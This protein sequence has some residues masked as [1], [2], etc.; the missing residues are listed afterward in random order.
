MLNLPHLDVSEVGG[1]DA[2]VVTGDWIARIGPVMRSLSPGASGWWATVMATATAFYQRWL[3]ADPL[4]RLSIK[5]EAV[6]HVHDFGSLSRV[7]ERGSV[8]ILQAMPTELQSEAVSTRALNC[9]ALLFLTMSR[10]QPGGSAEKASILAFLTQPQTEGPAG[11]VANHTALR[12]WERLFRRCTELGLQI[13]D[14]SLLVRA[15]DALGK[16]IGNKSPTAAWRL[17]SFRHQH[18]L[19]VQP[20]E[21]AVLKYCQLLTAELETL[22]L[23]QDAQKQQRVSV[24]QAEAPKVPRKAPTKAAPK[25][26][27][28]RPQPQ[29]P[30]PKLSSKSH[31]GP[32]DERGICKFFASPGGCRYGRTCLHPHEQL[33]PTDGRCFNCGAVGHSVQECD[34][35]TKPFPKTPVKPVAAESPAKSTTSSPLPKGG[36]P[37]RKPKGRKL[38]TALDASAATGESATFAAAAF[39]SEGDIEKMLKRAAC[40][41]GEPHIVATLNGITVGKTR[42]LL[43]GGATHSLRHAA[44][45]E[46]RLARPVQVHLASGSTFDLR[47]NAVGTLLSEDPEVQPIVP[48]G[49]LAEELGCVI[50]WKG[51]ECKVVHPELGKLGVTVSRGCPEVQHDVCLS[52]ILELEE[53]RSDSMLGKV[54]K[55]QVT[56]PLPSAIHVQK[57]EKTLQYLQEKVAEWFPEVPQ[58]TRARLLPRRAYP[59]AASG[60]NRHC[61]RKLERG[62]ALIHLFAWKQKNQHPSAIPAV[63]LDLLSGH[64]LRDDALFAYLLQ[65]AVQGKIRFLLAGPPCRTVSALRQRGSGENS[66]G[67]PGIVRKRTGTERFGIKGLESSALDVVEG[68]TLLI[69]RT[70]LLAEASN[71]GLEAVRIAKRESSSRASERKGWSLFFGLELPEDPLQYLTEGQIVDPQNV[72]TIWE[73]PE[74]KEFIR[75]NGLYEASFHQGRHRAV[76]PTKVI[77][78]SG[79]V[80]ERLHLLK[81]IKGELWSPSAASTLEGRLQQSASWAQWAPQ[82]VSFFRDGMEDWLLG[83]EHCEKQNQV[84]CANLEQLRASHC[85]ARTNS[86]YSLRAL[87][88]KEQE[89]FKRHCLAGHRPWRSDCAARLDAMAFSKP[90]RR[91]KRSRACALSIDVSGPHKATGA[92][93]QDIAKPK[94]FMVGCYTYPVFDQ[95]SAEARNAAKW[96][97]QCHSA[98]VK[99]VA[100]GFNARDIR[101]W[102][103]TQLAAEAV[104]L[105]QCGPH[106]HCKQ[107]RQGF[108][109][110]CLYALEDRQSEALRSF[111]LLR[112]G[113]GLIASHPYEPALSIARLANQVVQEVLPKEYYTTVMLLPATACSSD[114]V[115]LSCVETVSAWLL[116]VGSDNGG[117]LWTS[118]QKGDHVSR[119]LAC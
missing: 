88:G 86:G 94:Y 56:N 8:L 109:Q 6:N 29:H 102:T 65:L 21:H 92:E 93:D 34:K 2:S 18:H 69:L 91:L 12:K 112:N 14:P 80:W 116:D 45:S 25:A 72:P 74:V 71:D 61:R 63:Y 4:Q 3:Q 22:S 84:R 75:R 16:V 1:T 90:H 115:S 67:G 104:L 60:L 57:F 64:D 54:R 31:S 35:P 47:M 108:F 85:A 15:L 9:T 114:S 78:S 42:G 118:L 44:P 51:K 101:E 50:S 111:G 68:D 98:Q 99:E 5:T 76:K 66:D 87:S 58:V 52:L 13:P 20:T 43:D 119:E 10:F 36:L 33:S 110:S 41:D 37:K 19:D 79:Y 73:W 89:R 82:L 107:R 95:G 105:R 49:L 23:A 53:K 97:L 24:L 48:M 103:P 39:E 81:V 96:P 38:E 7:E 59:P 26:S 28:S 77:T 83:P 62:S 46:Y 27:T 55:A 32:F 106:G 40:V 70:I 17:Y 11:V 113:E 100:K 117:E 30:P